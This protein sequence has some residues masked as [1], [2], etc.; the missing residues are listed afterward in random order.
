MKLF[1]IN[2]LWQ[3]IRALLGWPMLL[4]GCYFA[5]TL[6]GSV[7]PVNSGWQETEDGV[8]LYLHDNGI[9]TSIILPCM[10]DGASDICP[11][12]ARD[13]PNRQVPAR[14]QMVGWGDRDFFLNTPTWG[15]FDMSTAIT[16]VKGSGGT[17]VHVDHLDNLPNA[18]LK[19]VRISRDAHQKILLR[20]LNEATLY[21]P[22][23]AKLRPIK[24]Y[25][26]NDLFYTGGNYDQTRYSMAYTCNNWVSDVLADAGIRT[27][28]W[29]PLS[30]GVM[31]WH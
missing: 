13:L 10:I 21:A 31:W 12:P 4:I 20:I 9:H 26:K 14:W 25:G 27:G 18:G 15:D 6:I 5:A 30:F 16:A 23:G 8:T 17:L 11:F 29:T 19:S 7:I 3:V 28:Y 2:S 24:G 1:R 22:D